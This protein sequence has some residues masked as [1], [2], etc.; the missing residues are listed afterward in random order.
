[1][2]IAI[3]SPKGTSPT[4][5]ALEN[6][7]D[8]NPDGAGY[9]FANDGKLIIRKGFFDFDSF[10]KSY[11]EDNI[12]GFN[13]LIHFRIS[14]SGQIDKRNCHPFLIT[15]NVAMIHNGII[16]NFGN[17]VENDTLQ[18]VKLVLK[19]IIKEGGV[20]VLL[21]PSIQNMII[22]SIG[23]SKLAFLDHKGNSYIFN[24][25]MG[26]RNNSI[27]Y[28]NNSYKETYP[29]N[30]YGYGFKPEED[31][32]YLNPYITCQEC[33]NELVNN[34][35]EICDSCDELDLDGYGRPI[36]RINKWIEV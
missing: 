3:N 36:E 15:E 1:M 29:I 34:E 9:C 22:D 2:C 16:P 25:K 10:L 19:P 23:N 6:S 28:S 17:K 11:Q 33:F 24:E 13:K 32:I 20:K 18:Y 5:N 26:H 7:F 14:T 4:K 30:N 8:Y 31:D 12:Q 27:W 21:N 35:Y